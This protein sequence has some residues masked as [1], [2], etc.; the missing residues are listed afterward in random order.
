LARVFHFTKI[1]PEELILKNT[2]R[3]L[4]LAPHP[5]DET[6][7]CAGLMINN[8]ENIE[9]ICL[10]DGRHGGYNESEEVLK[11]LR[12]QEFVSVMEKLGIKAYSFFDIEDRELIKNYDK[13][14]KIDVSKYDYVFIPNYFDQ[15]KDHKALTVL[16]QKLLKEQKHNN[17][18]KIV[19]YEVWSALTAINYFIDLT[20]IIDKKRELVAM[21]GSQLR[22]VDFLEGI[23]GLNR[24]RGMLTNRV[25]SETYCIIDVST[26]LKI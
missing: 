5:D 26:F 6:I 18:L 9:V 2:D 12:Q 22:H 15:H 19:Y 13:F 10:T 17:S 8:P 24:Y 4:I 14:S 7:G 25:S 23:T 21:Y 20:D 1:F 3:C 16:F 11:Q